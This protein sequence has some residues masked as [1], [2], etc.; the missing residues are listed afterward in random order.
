MEVSND[1]RAQALNRANRKRGVGKIAFLTHWVKIVI[2]SLALFVVIRAFGVEAFKIASGSMEHTL[3]EGDFLLINKLVYGAG[4][5]GSGRK[6]PALHSP[7]RGDVVVFTY[8]VDPRLNYVKRIVG[9]PGDT[10]E[11][12]DATLVRNGKRVH[13][14]YIQRTPDDPDQSDDDFR[15]QKA[16][17]VGSAS[18][19]NYHPSRNNWGPL[20]VPAHDYFVLGDNRDNSS[21]SRYWGFVADSLVRGQPLVVYYS[22]KPATGD[23]LDW[24]TRLRWKRFGEIVH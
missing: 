5:P 7:R 20:V 19:E 2:V 12:R 4:I 8:P 24:L 17:L 6:L 1:R 14:D 3:F 13:E 16:Y 15:W 9:I 23:R 10:L 21:D 11:M 22:Y 18:V